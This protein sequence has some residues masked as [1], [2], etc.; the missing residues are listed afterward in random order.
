MAQAQ[1]VQDA[2][3]Q[4]ISN[5]LAKLYGIKGTPILSTLSAISTSYGKI[6]FQI[7]FSS[8][9]PMLKILI[10]KI[11]VIPFH[12]KFGE[13]LGQVQL[14]ARQLFHL[15]LERQYLTLHYNNHR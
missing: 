14:P 15:H 12:L 3:N 10:T 13:K 5:W 11:K 1:E 8:G 4:T 2:P 7:S 9:L 6:L